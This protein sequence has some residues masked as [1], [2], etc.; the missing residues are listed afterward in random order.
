[1]LNLCADPTK[2]SEPTQPVL[3]GR[4]R[5]NFSTG[6]SSLVFLPSLNPIQLFAGVE[7]VRNRARR[8]FVN[9]AFFSTDF[10]SNPF[11]RAL[12]LAALLAMRNLQTI[13]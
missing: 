10:G 3:V 7:K 1:V 11:D 6:V 4:R 5:E 12:A 2:L 13:V 8:R 9:S